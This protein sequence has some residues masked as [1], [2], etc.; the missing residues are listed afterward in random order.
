M[1]EDEEMGKDLKGKELG[2]GL[3]QKTTGMYEGRF[4]NK[5]GKRV[6]IINRDLR[7]LK[8]DFERRKAE[9]VVEISLS[10]DKITMDKWFG[11]WDEI[12]KVPYV[13]P[14]TRATY[15]RSFKHHIQPY[16]GKK[17]LSEIKKTDCQKVLNK[18][19]DKGL[20]WAVQVHIKRLMID[21][22][23]KAYEDKL[24]LDNPARSI[25]T[26][27]LK[28]E[29]ERRVLTNLEQELFFECSAGSFYNNLF[30]VAVSSGLRPGELFALKWDDIDLK[31]RVIDVNK[32][33]VYQQ[34]LDDEG[35]V[36][37][38]EPPKH[39]SHR[40]V[41]IT[42]D[43]CYKSLVRQKKLKDII[44]MKE[45]RKEHEFNDRFFVTK[46]NTPLNS[47]IMAD[48]IK[49]VLEEVNLQLDSVEQIEGF[50]GHTFR[51]TFAT[52]C[53]NDDISIKA[54]Q[55][56]LGHKSLQM[57]MD[58]YVHATDDLTEQ[59]LKK[60]S[61]LRSS[62]KPIREAPS[63]IINIEASKGERALASSGT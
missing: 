25:R 30:V 2:V 20:G 53:I 39:N 7:V 13:Q 14:N 27:N 62:Y 17:K 21:I 16:L 49:K 15:H 28:P 60:V 24:V 51:H 31:N 22:F 44:S 6:T 47:Q 46:F 23:N 10:D 40:K 26:P 35:K 63:N 9:D 1:K 37:H 57:T 32:T 36:F 56:W 55:K 5:L 3:H 45:N 4:T 61:G 59:E 48:A 42:S 34:Y 11:K 12:Y 38:E 33:L 58:L 54:I 29:D 43:E 8:R 19:K 50:S 52:N 41:P 18:L